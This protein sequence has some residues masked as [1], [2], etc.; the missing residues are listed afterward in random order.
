MC[1]DFGL[2]KL[3]ASSKELTIDAILYN[4]VGSTSNGRLKNG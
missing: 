2:C 1:D 3:L 4:I